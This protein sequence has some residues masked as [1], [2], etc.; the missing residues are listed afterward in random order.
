MTV[1]G[2]VHLSLLSVTVDINV[3]HLNTF[4]CIV[5]SIMTSEKIYMSSYQ[6]FWICQRTQEIKTIS[7]SLLLLLPNMN[8]SAKDRTSSS[9]ISYLSSWQT[10]KEHCD[11]ITIHCFNFGELTQWNLL[12][13]QI[14]FGQHL[15]CNLAHWRPWKNDNNNNTRRERSLLPFIYFHG[16]GNK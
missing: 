5:V 1:T 2:L 12:W 10:L 9:K 4:Y 13:R 11:S 14:T 16:S 6:T 8:T 15:W 3:K 7:D